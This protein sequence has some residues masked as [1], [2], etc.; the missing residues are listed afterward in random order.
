[1]KTSEYRRATRLPELKKAEREVSLLKKQ[2]NKHSPL[3]SVNQMKALLSADSLAQRKANESLGRRG[4][5]KIPAETSPLTQFS[6]SRFR[7]HV[8]MRLKLH[9]W[10]HPSCYSRYINE[11]LTRYGSARREWRDGPAGSVRTIRHDVHFSSLQFTDLHVRTF[12]IAHTEKH[13]FMR[14][15]SQQ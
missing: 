10:H 3:K 7:G 1:M 9:E 8:Q 2:W 13:E 12:Y 11:I 5:Y 4:N 6:K 15:E 14:P